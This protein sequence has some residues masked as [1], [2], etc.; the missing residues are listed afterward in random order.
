MPIHICYHPSSLLH[1]AGPGH[2]E[3]PRRLEA[4]LARL[5]QWSPA[6]LVWHE[7]DAAPDAVISQ[8]HAMRYVKMLTAV[9]AEGGGRLDADTAMSAH[10]LHAARHAAGAALLAARLAVEH[11]TAFAPVRPPGHHAT[12]DRAMGFCLFN[13]VVIA[14]RAM[15]EDPAIERVLIVDW[16]VHHGNGTQAIVETDE[17]IRYVSLHQWP[18]YPGTGRVEERG[19]GNIFNVP[20]PPGLAPEEYVRSL[21]DAVTQAMQ[22]WRPNLVLIS[23]G[24]DAMAGD[25]LAGFTL[26]PEHYAEWVAEWRRE[27]VPI[28]SVLEGGYVPE[29]LADGVAAHLE[30]LM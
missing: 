29:R 28:A 20:R 18:L 11:G 1:D 3:S 10:S 17:R 2:P 26:E 7:A 16:D 6:T 9:D 5:R 19:V 15:L 25:P 27:G 4:I 23:A 30:A 13:N 21:A 22:G 8:V 14:A 12:A 24:F